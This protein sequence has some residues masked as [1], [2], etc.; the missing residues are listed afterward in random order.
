MLRRRD[1]AHHRPRRE[2][3]P[4]VPLA[5]E[6][7][8]PPVLAPGRDRDA[9]RARLGDDVAGV[10]QRLANVGHRLVRAVVELLSVTPRSNVRCIPSSS[11]GVA[12]RRSNAS[13]MSIGRRTG[14][15]C[16]RRSRRRRGG[17]LEGVKPALLTA[18]A[19]GAPSFS[20]DSPYR[21]NVALRLPAG[22]RKEAGRRRVNGRG[23]RVEEGVA[24][25]EGPSRGRRL[26]PIGVR[27]S[28]RGGGRGS[29]GRAKERGRTVGEDVVRLR[30]AR[31][32][33][34]GI[35]GV[36]P[37]GVVLEREL[38]IPAWTAGG[39]GRASSARRIHDAR[40]ANARV[41]GDRRPRGAVEP[42][43]RHAAFL[44]SASVA[45]RLKP[46]SS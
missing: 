23:S 20:P 32:H 37:V 39:R 25:S 21:S 42:G 16:R 17:H 44:M 19:V 5:L 2:P 40:G 41:R 14:S 43:A 6:H 28:P 24:P 8:P 13:E 26:F 35:L 46:S 36:V 22:G 34:D 45:E 9:E 30:D 38:A 18:A 29:V 27:H 7:E 31:E 11:S 12:V 3:R 33:R 4:H 10:R 1:R 15:P